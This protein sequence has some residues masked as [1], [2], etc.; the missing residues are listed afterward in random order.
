MLFLPYTEV[1]VEFESPDGDKSPAGDESLPHPL[2][3]KLRR[4]K[5]VIEF[6][7]SDEAK[8]QEPLGDVLMVEVENI[9][10]E[11][12]EQ[13][14]EIKALKQEIIKTIRDIVTMNPIYRFVYIIWC[15]V[16]V[17]PTKF[18]VLQRNIASIAGSESHGGQSGLFV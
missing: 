3:R 16:H 12:F 5:I 11:K 1:I 4:K 15:M 8:Q 13:T 9:V 17:F 14:Q 18:H 10:H 7:K 6:D 2:R